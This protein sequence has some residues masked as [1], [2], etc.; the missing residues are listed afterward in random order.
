[1]KVAVPRPAAVNWFVVLPVGL[2]L[3]AMAAGRSRSGA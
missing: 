1:M 2:Y 3:A